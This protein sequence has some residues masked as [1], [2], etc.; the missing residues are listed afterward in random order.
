MSVADSF[1]THDPTNTLELGS[2]SDYLS[3]ELG[4]YS[5]FDVSTELGSSSPELSQSASAAGISSCTSCDVGVTLAPVAGDLYG[6]LY[7][8]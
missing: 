8:S 3:G 4:S 1:N 6:L 7:P 2:T 5:V